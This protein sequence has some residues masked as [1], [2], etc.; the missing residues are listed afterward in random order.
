MNAMRFRLDRKAA[1]YNFAGSLRLF[2]SCWREYGNLLAGGWDEPTSQLDVD[3]ALDQIAA[4]KVNNPRSPFYIY[5][6]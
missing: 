5:G 3:Q 2:D 1:A 4:E 6:E